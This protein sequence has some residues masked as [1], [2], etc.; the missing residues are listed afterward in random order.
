MEVHLTVSSRKFR[1]YYTKIFHRLLEPG[2]KVKVP[3]RLCKVHISSSGLFFPGVDPSCLKTP[4]I[5]L[6]PP[7]QC[8]KVKNIPFKQFRN[9]IQGIKGKNGGPVAYE[10]VL[11]GL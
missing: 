9:I 10:V 7:Q 2:I 8:R 1:T 3:H 4:Q 11:S 5:I 6:V